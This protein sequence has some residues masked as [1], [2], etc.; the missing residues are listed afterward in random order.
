MKRKQ[1]RFGAVL[2]VLSLAVAAGWWIQ[3][4]RS[5]TDPS[6][7]AENETSKNVLKSSDSD[8]S[9]TWY[10]TDQGAITP[11]VLTPAAIPQAVAPGP[12]P[13]VD[14]DG[15]VSSSKMPDVTPVSNRGMANASML[16]RGQSMEEQ[17]Q[18]VDEPNPL[19]YQPVGPSPIAAGND[20]AGPPAADVPTAVA[21]VRAIHEPRTI[22]PEAESEAQPLGSIPNAPVRPAAHGVPTPAVGDDDSPSPALAPPGPTP[23][24]GSFPP[25]DSNSIDPMDRQNTTNVALPSQALSATEQPL[26]PQSTDLRPSLP[27]VPAGPLPINQSSIAGT[28][29][30]GAMLTPQSL[31]AQSNILTGNGMGRPG[32]QALEGP[33][34]PSLTIEKRA[35]E[36]IQ[37]GKECTFEILVRNTGRSAAHQ[38]LVYD[39]I[40]QGTQ[41]VASSP[42]ANQAANGQLVWDIGTIGPGEE[43]SIEVQLMPTEEGD[44]GSVATVSFA[45]QASIR[46]R[47]TR[48]L[49]EL[50]TTAGP[51][52]MI[53]DEHVVSVEIHNPGSGDATGVMLLENIPEGVSH[54]SGP[55]LEYEIGTLQAGETRKLDLVLTAEQAGI[56]HNRLVAQGDANLHVESTLDFEVIAPDLRVSIDGP[57]RRYLEREATYVVAVDNPGTASAKDIELVTRL[58]KGMQFVKANNL[59]EYD[60]SSHTVH[61][62]LAELPPNERGTV[63]LV[64]LAVEAGEQR[65]QV[66]TKAAQ[67]L[68]DQTEQPVVV[69]GLA[70]IMFEVVDVD[71]PIEV[72]GET[73]YEVRV[74]NQGSKTATNL[75]VVAILP[76]GMTATDANGPVQHQI[77]QGQ[78]IFAP[79][80]RLAPKADTTY[81]VDVQGIQPGDQRFRVQV[82][83]SEVQ[84]P[85]TKEEST[86]VYTDQ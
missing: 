78:V 42:Q 26:G 40:P 8:V 64:M 10:S 29:N 27:L 7:T 83:T 4:N 63:E 36:E 31:Q 48:P 1:F 46:T 86:R 70:A 50:R 66:E 25:S 33:Q 44:I 32:E 84:Q 54:P 16:A 6:S 55:S 23:L 9:S 68:A 13:E 56:V 14:A 52:V 17:D 67:G 60:A 76:P 49:L 81:R 72:G 5:A 58:P 53:G 79:L 39:D 20:L 18:R 51:Q 28:P 11:T 38:V 62:S 12:S 71:D 37:V 35:P 73:S 57:S 75:Q 45:S 47:C 59:G 69:E 15:Y 30:D 80:A 61:W 34:A 22:A 65:L 24:P 21:G 3:R 19:R 2:V 82:T 74:V 85:I 77:D 43:Q 41:Y